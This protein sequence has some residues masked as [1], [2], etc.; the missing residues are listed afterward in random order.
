VSEVGRGTTFSI[1]LPKA[2]YAPRPDEPEKKPAGGKERVLFVDDEEILIGSMGPMLE[3]LGYRVTTR[4]DALEALDLFLRHPDGFDLVIT[5]QT[6]PRMTGIDL[7][8]EI[9]RVRPGLPVILCTGFSENVT[10]EDAA[11]ALGV[12]AVLMK[13]FTIQEMAEAI[14]RALPRADKR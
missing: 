6:M 2:P 1:L 8:R 5:D 4:S 3:R 11:S 13:P 9:L 7:A 12:R 10:G 14:R